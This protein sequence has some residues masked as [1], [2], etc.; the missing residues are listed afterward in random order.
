MDM[1]VNHIYAVALS[2]SAS[3]D[4]PNWAIT[5]Q[6][7]KQ[8]RL[9]F[10]DHPQT[11]VFLSTNT[12]NSERRNSDGFKGEELLVKLLIAEN[13]VAGIDNRVQEVLSK[14]DKNQP[15]DSWLRSAILALQQAHLCNKFSIDDFQ[16][17]ATQTLKSQQS[18]HETVAVEVDFLSELGR[19]Q[20][21]EEMHE[22]REKAM[23]KKKDSSFFGFRI[24]RPQAMPKKVR[25][26]NSWERQDDAY[27]GLM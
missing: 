4:T 11:S 23:N 6:P 27:G 26:V 20:S 9:F 21:V 19:T 10:H 8:K 12:D 7:K 1:S 3:A 15:S 5:V 22:T 24:T 14:V 2:D 17:M 13:D 18:H 25:R 16:Q